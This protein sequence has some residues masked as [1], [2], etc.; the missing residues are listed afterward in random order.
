MNDYLQIFVSLHKI[1]H[2]AS[3]RVFTNRNQQ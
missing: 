2:S 1:K 3:V